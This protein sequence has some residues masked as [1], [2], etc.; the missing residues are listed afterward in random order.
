[1]VTGVQTCALPISGAPYG[2][3][4][5]CLGHSAVTSFGLCVSSSSITGIGLGD[6]FVYGFSV[7]S[8]FSSCIGTSFAL[9]AFCV[10]GIFIFMPG[11]IISG[12]DNCEF[13]CS[14]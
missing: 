5:R 12:L 8:F 14:S 13:T 3:C 6:K 2:A 4:G 9:T 1:N 10:L 11:M 7:F